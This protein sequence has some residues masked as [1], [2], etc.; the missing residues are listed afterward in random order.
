MMLFAEQITLNTVS[1]SEQAPTNLISPR[2]GHEQREGMERKRERIKGWGNKVDGG[3]T[4]G[5]RRYGWCPG[6]SKKIREGEIDPERRRNV[7]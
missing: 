1:G 6:K 5:G 2:L 4:V 7:G 3:A